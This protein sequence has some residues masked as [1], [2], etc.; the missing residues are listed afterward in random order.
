MFITEADAKRIV[1]DYLKR[2]GPGHVQDLQLDDVSMTG[3]DVVEVRLSSAWSP[4]LVSEFFPLSLR[5][6]VSAEAQSLIR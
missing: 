4:P 2:A 6:A 5:V 3:S 1:L